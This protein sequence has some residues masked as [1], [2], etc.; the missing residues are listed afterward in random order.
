MTYPEGPVL[1]KRL[2][3]IENQIE[4]LRR[5]ELVILEELQAVHLSGDE[6]LADA[7]VRRLNGQIEALISL[8]PQKNGDRH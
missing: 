8:K 2:I 4:A 3:R 1:I 7:A 6:A 5:A